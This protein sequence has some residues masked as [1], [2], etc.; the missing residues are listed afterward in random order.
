[1]DSN[2]GSILDEE[3]CSAMQRIY[4]EEQSEKCLSIQ[5]NLDESVIMEGEEG[6][7]VVV[8]IDDAGVLDLEREVVLE[9]AGDGAENV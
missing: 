6:S 8:S 7:L 2:Q 5:S 9:Q 3:S 1:M 4:R